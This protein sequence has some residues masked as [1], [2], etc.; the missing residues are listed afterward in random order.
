[1]L[2][3][4]LNGTI[5]ALPDNISGMDTGFAYIGFPYDDEYWKWDDGDTVI[6]C[7]PDHP[8]AMRVEEAYQMWLDQHDAEQA[9]WEEYM[10]EEDYYSNRNV[11][12]RE[13]DAAWEPIERLYEIQD[14][15]S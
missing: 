10:E 11:M 9:A 3:T 15:L 4:R 12:Q 1:M 8:R 6:G 7:Q 14:A 2:I 13:E 5:T